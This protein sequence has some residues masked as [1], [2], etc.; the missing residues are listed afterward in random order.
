M[1]AYAMMGYRLD[2]QA[3]DKVVALLRIEDIE[4]LVHNLVLIRDRNG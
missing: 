4:A 2:W 3:L 1:Q